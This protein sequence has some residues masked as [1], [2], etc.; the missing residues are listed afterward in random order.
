[1]APV[2]A[3][4]GPRG[5]NQTRWGSLRTALFAFFAFF[6]RYASHLRQHGLHHLVVAAG[7]ANAVLLTKPLW[8]SLEDV[9]STFAHR[10]TAAVV[11]SRSEV[12]AVKHV[13]IVKIDKG[14]FASPSHYAGTSPLDRCQLAKDLAVLLGANN[15]AIRL[16][17]VDL[18]L[19]P[20]ERSEFDKVLLSDVYQ[21]RLDNTGRVETMDRAKVALVC[22]D[23]LD[24]LVRSN[25]NR[26]LL[27]A[28]LAGND[29]EINNV[30]QKWVVDMQA[31]GVRFANA[32][33][34][35]TRGLVRNQYR[36]GAANAGDRLPYF[37]DAV[38]QHI[39]PS[40]AKGSQREEMAEETPIPL[41]ALGGLFERGR[42][43]N[44]N[45]ACLL[46]RFK[47]CDFN[48]ILF[49]AGYS[50][51]DE[52]ETPHGKLHGIDIH[53][54][55]AACPVTTR[56]QSVQNHFLTHALEILCGMLLLAPVMHFFWSKY[57]RVRSGRRMAEVRL[58]PR[59]HTNAE[60]LYGAPAASAR[61]LRAEF[62]LVQPHTAFVWLLGLGAFLAG[63]WIVISGLAQLWSS[64]CT[65]VGIQAAFVVGMLVE[66][67]VVQSVQVAA[68]E[69]H[70]DQESKQL[71]LP[72]AAEGVVAAFTPYRVVFWAAYGAL[73]VCAF[74]ELMH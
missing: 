54:A 26:L 29:N 2:S 60:W 6:A 34:R 27:M 16:V 71:A 42:D 21:S 10:A 46:P 40:Q 74:I 23:R 9:A 15:G 69:M 20:I 41:H 52:Y 33:L 58:Q 61:T 24:T 72:A 1:M 65:V 25:A 22:Q 57:Y 64:I 63:F 3:S 11:A 39:Q 36:T 56:A 48:V 51:D 14:R 67:A 37:G 73:F 19:S 55:N 38:H 5:V 44:F 53:A 4:P 7:V 49:G 35:A 17:A 30:I 70:A 32:E 50:A 31:A 59:L 47:P 66:G 13:A 62:A 45:D 68:H 43:L 18:D 28:P 8:V 12:S